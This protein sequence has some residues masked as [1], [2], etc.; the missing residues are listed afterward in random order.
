MLNTSPPCFVTRKGAGTSRKSLC[1]QAF[2]RPYRSPPAPLILRVIWRH[3]AFYALRGLRWKRVVPI[4]RPSSRKRLEAS[5]RTEPRKICFRLLD[6]NRNELFKKHRFF[7][8]IRNII[9]M[10]TRLYSTYW[11]DKSIFIARSGTIPIGKV[12]CQ[13]KGRDM[14]I[15]TTTAC[16]LMGKALKQDCSGTCSSPRCRM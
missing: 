8:T 7:D 3:G 10:K 14:A 16:L 4:F 13:Q 2:H 12:Q 5:E 1:D 9:A 15:H 6:Y 11:V